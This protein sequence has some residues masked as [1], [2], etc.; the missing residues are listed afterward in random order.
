MREE[1]SAGGI[2]Y[3]R[4]GSPIESGMTSILV[5]VSKHSG[6]HGWVFPKGHVGDKIK[7]ET[8][9]AAALRETEE[10]TGIK[11]TIIQPLSPIDYWFVQNAE[12]IHK[13]VWYFLM[14]YSSG[15]IKDHDFEM[16]EVE[17]LPIF[18]VENRLTYPGDK[19]V[20]NEARGLL[21]SGI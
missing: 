15:D 8:K 10:E 20:W 13:A 19:K 3:K 21:E 17:W 14:E 1:V 9:E 18:Q 6:H 16:E 11:G 2:V 4:S 5:L 7:G 12:K